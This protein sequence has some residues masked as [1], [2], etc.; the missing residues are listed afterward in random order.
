MYVSPGYSSMPV[1]PNW[2]QAKT[3]AKLAH[4]CAK[5]FIAAHD[6]SL[7]KVAKDGQEQCLSGLIYQMG[8]ARKPG[9]LRDAP[10]V[11]PSMEDA[12]RYVTVL[13][14][15]EIFLI[16]LVNQEGKLRSPKSLYKAFETILAVTQDQPSPVE[17]PIP[18]LTTT[19]RRDWFK[20]RS[21]LKEADPGNKANLRYIE[22]SLTVICLDEHTALTDSERTKNQLVGFKNDIYNR[23]CDKHQLIVSAVP[24]DGFSATC[25]HAFSDAMVWSEWMNA[26]Y[27]DMTSKGTYLPNP[28]RSIISEKEREFLVIDSNNIKPHYCVPTPTTAVSDEAMIQAQSQ[29]QSSNNN[30][31]NNSNIQEEEEDDAEGFPVSSSGTT[32]DDDALLEKPV[33]AEQVKQSKNTMRQTP[34]GIVHENGVIRLSFKLNDPAKDAVTKAKNYFSKEVE[35]LKQVGISLPFGKNDCKNV[36]KISPDALCQASYHL[37]YARTH[38]MMAP[39]YE[40]CSTGKFFHGRTETIRSATPEMNEFVRSCLLLSSSSSSSSSS[41]QAQVSTSLLKKA[42]TAHQHIGKEAGNGEGVDRHLLA[43]KLLVT[44]FGDKDG[45]AFFSD[46]MY[47]RSGTWYMSTSNVS[48]PAL[49]W[50]SFGPVTPLGYG[51][52]YCVKDECVNVAV[53]STRNHYPEDTD[54][55]TDAE[56]LSRNIQDACQDILSM[57]KKK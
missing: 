9:A 38:Q 46:E 17:N 4:S 8:F 41:E 25:E 1:K 2:N 50:F 49:G 45:L 6:G 53:S 22:D 27:F 29:L 39:T 7:P 35:G 15:G 33:S 3:A 10:H 56:L 44:E 14:K 47:G 13:R 5:W 12:V 52:G 34:V 43:L 28:N 54:L 26:V 32:Y 57:L 37:G 18:V 11:A 20:A 42:A 36:L 48:Q 16:S 19:N 40:S 24:G 55:E 51:L 23:W 30:N 21:V 31:N